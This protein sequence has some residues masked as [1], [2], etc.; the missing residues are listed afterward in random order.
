M[1]IV[2]FSMRSPSSHTCMR[3][4]IKNINS[5]QLITLGNHFLISLFSKSY[6]NNNYDNNDN[7]SCHLSQ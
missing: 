3:R 5:G 2:S 1:K 4:V 7:Q 6:S